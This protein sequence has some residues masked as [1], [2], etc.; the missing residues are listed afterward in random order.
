MNRSLSY[1][2]MISFCRV[3]SPMILLLKNVK[4]N[5]IFLMVSY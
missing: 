2:L 4:L 1:S 5:L 3:R